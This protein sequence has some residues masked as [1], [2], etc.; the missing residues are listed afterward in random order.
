MSV[1]IQKL[2][3][4]IFEILKSYGKTLILYD[5]SGNVTYTPA[6]ATRI[7]IQP[8]KMMLSISNDGDD[9]EVKLYMSNNTS[10]ID[11]MKL[12]NTLRQTCT[13]LN[14]MFNVR[15]YGK[16]LSPKDFA[17]QVVGEDLHESY[18]GSQRTSY[19]KIGECK[20]IF[21][22]NKNINEELKGSRSRNIKN[23]YIENKNKEKYLFPTN[24]I[25]GAKAIA[26]HISS[27]GSIYDRVG[28]Y[29]IETSKEY[30]ILK[31][32]LPFIGKDDDIRENIKTRMRDINKTFDVIR[33]SRNYKKYHDFFANKSLYEFTNYNNDIE[34]T[35]EDTYK[36]S[37]VE[38]SIPYIVSIMSGNNSLLPH[39]VIESDNGILDII[40]NF[41]R[42]FK[43]GID[44]V[45]SDNNITF[46]NPNC[47]SDILH[48]SDENNIP[49]NIQNTPE[50]NNEEKPVIDWIEVE[51]IHDL[52][53]AINMEL[54]FEPNV[55]YIIDN[56]KI[57]FYS[58][59]KLAEILN[60]LNITNTNFV[61]I[62]N[63]YD[64]MNEEENNMPDNSQ[65]KILQF[66]TQWLADNTD[67]SAKLSPEDTT[68]DRAAIEG[69]AKQLSDELKNFMRSSTS[70]EGIEK[71][72]AR[73]F[74]SKRDE[75]AYKI[76]SVAEAPG[77]HGDVLFNFLAALSEKIRNS[78][79][80]DNNEKAVASKA[81][82]LYNSAPETEDTTDQRSTE[83]SQEP[84]DEVEESSVVE[85]E[86]YTNLLSIAW[87]NIPQDLYK[88]LNSSSFGKVLAQEGDRLNGHV[89]YDIDPGKEELFRTTVKR[90]AS[91]YNCE[92]KVTVSRV[93]EIKKPKE[94]GK[95]KDYMESK[96]NE[97]LKLD[98]W[99]NQFDPDKIIKEDE[100]ANDI[101]ADELDKDKS[102]VECDD[103][104]SSTEINETEETECDEDEDE[105]EDETPFNKKDEGELAESINYIKN[106]GK[107]NFAYLENGNGN[108]T[109]YEEKTLTPIS[110]ITNEE[111]ADKLC[112]SY[113][114]GRYNT[115]KNKLISNLTEE[116]NTL[117]K[118]I[119]QENL[120]EEQI[121]KLAIS[122][123][124]NE[125]AISQYSPS[126][127]VDV[128][129]S[130]GVERNVNISS[131]Y[132]MITSI[133]EQ[134]F[135]LA[136]KNKL[137]EN[138]DFT[139]EVFE[140]SASD[141]FKSEIKPRLKECGFTFDDEPE[142]ETTEEIPDD[143]DISIIKAIPKDNG[144]DSVETPITLGDLSTL[145][146]DIFSS[147]PEVEIDDTVGPEDE[148]VEVDEDYMGR[149]LHAITKNAS[150]NLD[151]HHLINTGY[152]GEPTD[153]SHREEQILVNQLADLLYQQA[154]ENDSS[155]K[156]S[157]LTPTNFNGAASQLFLSK[158]KDFVDAGFG[159]PSD[160]PYTL[161][162]DEIGDNQS[163]IDIAR[164]MGYDAAKSGDKDRFDSNLR[165]LMNNHPGDEQREDIH[166]AFIDGMD[167][168][169][170]GRH[171][172]EG[173]DLGKKGKNF[174]KIAKSAGKEYGSKEAGEKVAGAVLAKLRK[175][176]PEE[177]SESS[178]PSMSSITSKLDEIFNED[179]AELDIT[180][181]ADNTGIDTIPTDV[182]AT[183]R[184]DVESD[185]VDNPHS[186]MLNDL[187]R[188][189][190]LA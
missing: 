55:D 76:S 96:S 146:S 22:H 109:I 108:F 51:N 71:V 136:S 184:N 45:I 92:N 127:E 14:S 87:K 154:L 187:R 54:G 16:E 43:Y 62:P 98:E 105:D 177:Y 83:T 138:I 134:L 188:R 36:D 25:R 59:E 61:K 4:E 151:V 26:R 9:N 122:K 38:E 131:E 152:F 116:L 95:W 69:K 180:D 139:S 8:E 128:N 166:K 189:A 68:H 74:R 129:R 148:Q 57:G 163:P 89:N 157:T 2:A 117:T 183:M 82:S 63:E 181:D 185:I 46:Y 153:L 3:E 135:R 174:S 80:L 97:D 40:N 20:V 160:S 104:A 121:K 81:I 125:Y 58:G 107:L 142:I 93:M 13:R 49:Y 164:R 102:E 190:G 12:I 161:E 64:N 120:N 113:N 11:M 123:K 111:V 41:K 86:D 29:I 18:W 133:S 88:R 147:S 17:Y 169:K 94:I 115:I 10:L 67:S 137:F 28:D 24:N 178:S 167:D 56:N 145:L 124:L 27:G 44:Y 47:L 132:G 176:H 6:Q 173:K 19:C 42:K 90:Y 85:S 186:D 60:L 77:L 75:Q 159:F 179:D 37:L 103:D 171:V 126:Y 31:K 110:I 65:D 162:E 91:M 141:I 73:Q 150:S 15:K 72:S 35:L 99:F 5:G 172:E 158:K 165:A 144:M 84:S 53:S 30:D 23:I 39:L 7:F 112:N 119:E 114:G 78:L 118:E 168:F 34:K 175:E 130:F 101:V 155:L 106:N 140:S 182:Q 50:I 170:S 66:A 1:L 48:F 143:V 79:P 149:D 70:V 100:D 33:G 21:H 32:S 156:N 52:L